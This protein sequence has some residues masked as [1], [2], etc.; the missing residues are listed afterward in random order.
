M[1]VV[2]NLFTMFNV[3]TLR[4]T[5]EEQRMK[6]CNDHSDSADQASHDESFNLANLVLIIG[7]KLTAYIGDAAST[8]SVVNWLRDGLPAELE[9]R[10]KA[11][12]DVAKPV[13]EVESELVAQGFLIRKWEQLGT[14]QTPAHMLRE[15]DV[16]S[17][18]SVLT[19]LAKAEFLSNEV[20]NLEEVT[21][22]LQQW[23]SCAEFPEGVGYTC[24]MWA[25]RMGFTLVHGGFTEEVQRKWDAGIGWP[26]WS[27]I[28]AA[29][30]EMERSRLNIDL[31]T[32]CPFR[33]LRSRR[34][35]KTAEE[36]AN[37]EVVNVHKRNS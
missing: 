29:V 21:G 16:Q 36:S 7:Y 17:A 8:K 10:M 19:R 18:R 12:F 34:L 4:R 1:Q 28:I 37:V 26:C 22:R 31:T 20:P 23:I 25:D 24:H 5:Q 14:Y 9:S 13:A 6:A 33:Y 35:L 30:P 3:V 32:G 15:A 2:Q 11:A 27:E